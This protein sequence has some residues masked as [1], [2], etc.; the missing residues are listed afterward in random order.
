LPVVLSC[1]EVRRIPKEVRTPVYRMCLKT[2]YS[3]GLRLL[4]GAHLRVADIDGE[5][6]TLFWETGSW[7]SMIE[8][9]DGEA[10][11]INEGRVERRDRD[12]SF[13]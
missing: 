10:I 7:M 8:I 1:E 4:E 5:T 9:I 11:T 6:M 13:V 12:T 3:C 2:I